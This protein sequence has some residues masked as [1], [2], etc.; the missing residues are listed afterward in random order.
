MSNTPSS[1]DLRVLQ[2][3]LQRLLDR[4]MTEQIRS[5]PVRATRAPD[6]SAPAPPAPSA[7]PPPATAPVPATAT[8]APTAPVS[9][10]APVA[11]TPAAAAPPS[12]AAKAPVATK[13]RAPSKTPSAANALI[14]FEFYEADESA[15]ARNPAGP[16]SS[17]GRRRSTAPTRTGRLHERLQQLEEE[18]LRLSLRA[19]V[20]EE[21][22]WKAE[23]VY[24]EQIRGLRDQVAALERDLEAA[25]GPGTPEPK[26]RLSRMLGR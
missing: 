6:T 4:R 21:A 2:D 9:A 5:E 16:R 15:A 22:L 14:G 3:D 17:I 8:T 20:A 24:E 7:P 11:P 13:V 10:K 23:R 1:E 12:A 18:V 25:R 26:R 19:E